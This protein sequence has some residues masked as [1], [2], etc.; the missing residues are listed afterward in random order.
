MNKRIKIS[1]LAILMC[2]AL[3]IGLASA[4]L[5]TSITFGPTTV[6]DPAFV[7]TL[8]TNYAT[9]VGSTATTGESYQFTVQLTQPNVVSIPKMCTIN[10]VITDADTTIAVPDVTL[11]Y[12]AVAPEVEGWKTL[13]L[14][15]DSNT[16]TGTFGPVTGFPVGTAY[17][18][19]TQLRV[20]YNIAGVYSGTVTLNS[21]P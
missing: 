21:I 13:S 7:A 5:L 8:T 4:A 9:A 2:T 17:D 19:T 3:I 1:T 16:L 10:F 12:Y 11:E 14:T 15:A 18:V 20:T 6:T